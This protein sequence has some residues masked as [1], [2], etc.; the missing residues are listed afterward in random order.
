MLPSNF[1]TPRQHL[2]PRTAPTAH[3]PHRPP[4]HR[5]D[6]PHLPTGF[7]PVSTR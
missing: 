2:R 4:T 6:R 3:A 1:T 7:I 5:T